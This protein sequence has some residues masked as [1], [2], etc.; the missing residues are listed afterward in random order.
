MVG[1]HSG[2]Q[3]AVAV[4]EVAD[5][6]WAALERRHEHSAAALAREQDCVAAQGALAQA[7][8]E[9]QRLRATIEQYEKAL[10]ALQIDEGSEAAAQPLDTKQVN[11]P[12]PLSIFTAQAAWVCHVIC[13]LKLSRW[14]CNSRMRSALAR[15]RVMHAA[16]ILQQVLQVCLRKSGFDI[17]RAWA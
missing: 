10:E 5:H 4:A 16:Q 3:V 8:Q 11:I 17:S 14:V 9:N 1:S 6:A 7:R 2:L 12:V 15:F 13:F